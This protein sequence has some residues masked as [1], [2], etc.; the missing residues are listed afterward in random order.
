LPRLDGEIVL[1]EVM[2]L[3][4]TCH[5]PIVVVTGD[6]RG[7]TETTGL[8]ILLKPVEPDALLSAVRKCLGNRSLNP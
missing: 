1:Q 8:C 2:S 6:P 3:R 7:L 5:I 4:T